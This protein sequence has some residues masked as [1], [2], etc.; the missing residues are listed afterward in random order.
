MRCIRLGLAGSRLLA[1]TAE[2]AIKRLKHDFRGLQG[3]PGI[4]LAVLN[5]F[6]SHVAPAGQ[7]T[8]ANLK[9]EKPFW[10]RLLAEVYFCIRMRPFAPVPEYLPKEPG[11]IPIPAKDFEQ[12]GGAAEAEGNLAEND[13]IPLPDAEEPNGDDEPVP[14]G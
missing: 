10:K 12:T 9:R 8:G 7:R 11:F 3:V 1:W 2:E 5:H 14:H 13:E 4:D 6:M